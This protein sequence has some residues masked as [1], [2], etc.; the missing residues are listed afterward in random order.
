MAD[1]NSLNVSSFDNGFN[2][3]TKLKIEKIDQT[4]GEYTLF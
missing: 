3:N 4:F 1:I 2:G